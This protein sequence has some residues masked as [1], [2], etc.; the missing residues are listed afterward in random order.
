MKK[1]LILLTFTLL[2]L[3][4]CNDDNVTIINSNDNNQV[5]SEGDNDETINESSNN[6]NKTSDEAPE[7]PEESSEEKTKG[8][9]ENSGGYEDE[10]DEGWI[11]L[12]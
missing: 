8:K 2:F 12:G 10:K 3:V 6:E 5:S 9:I 11:Y 1:L 7:E 4:S